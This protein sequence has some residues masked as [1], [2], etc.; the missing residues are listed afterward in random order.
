[1]EDQVMLTEKGNEVVARGGEGE[2]GNK[3]ICYLTPTKL[4][5]V[6]SPI[7]QIS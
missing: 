5:T 2:G 1:M 4:N 3:R 6:S 7:L